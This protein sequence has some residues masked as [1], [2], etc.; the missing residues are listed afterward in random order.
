MSHYV[1]RQSCRP[2]G[3]FRTREVDEFLDLVSDAFQCSV[4]YDL[5]SKPVYWTEEELQKIFEKAAARNLPGLGAT[6]YFY[7]IPPRKRDDNTVAIEI[8]TGT[9]P[10]EVFVDTYDI[11][12]GDRRKLP[13]FNY[14]EKSIQIFKPFE[15][16]L[17]EAENEYQMDAYN[18]QVPTFNKPAIIR[19]FHYLDKDLARSIGGIDYCLKAPAWHVERFCEGVLIELVPGPFDSDNPEHLKIQEEVMHYFDLW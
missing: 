3:D 15:A 7:T 10:G 2:R 13:D 4:V 11:S 19:G 8:H 9:Q 5:R 18:R 14:F 12:M 17:S 1:F 16:Y 6:V